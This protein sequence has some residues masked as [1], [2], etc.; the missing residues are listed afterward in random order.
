MHYD[1]YPP[2]V[3]LVAIGVEEPHMTE[4]CE[5]E[6]II[7]EPTDDPYCAACGEYQDVEDYPLP[8]DYKK[9]AT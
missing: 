8:K 5:H 7:N 4:P 1:N 3:D 2:G 9:L 6:H